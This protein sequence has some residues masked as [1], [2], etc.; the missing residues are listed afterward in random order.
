MLGVKVRETI[1]EN[2]IQNDNVHANSINNLPIKLFK[3]PT[4]K[5]TAESVKVITI[6]ANL[7]SL[8]AICGVP[9]IPSIYHLYVSIYTS[10]MDPSWVG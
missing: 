9:W 1:P 8:V 5:N 2:N 6:T 3:N 7:I 4:G 10:T